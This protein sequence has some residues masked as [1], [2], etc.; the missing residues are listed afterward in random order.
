MQ[1]EIT[2]TYL[3]EK[4]RF[5]G[6]E[7][8][9]IIA[10]A[11]LTDSHKIITIKGPSA[12][13]E[14]KSGCDYVFFGKWSS[15]KNK[16]TGQMEQQF[17]FSSFV[18]EEPASREA[19]IAY[20]VQHGEGHGIGNSRAAALFDLF[21]ND[22]VKV[23]RED[24]LRVA[25]A[26]SGRLKISL[27]QAKQL[28]AG[29]LAN[30]AIEKTKLG[31]AS[32]LQGRG[33]ARSITHLSI[34]KWGVAAARVIRRD[35]FKLMAFKSCGFKRC[36]AMYLDLKLN[37]ARLKRQALCAWHSIARNTDGSTWFTEAHPT[38]FIRS[39]VAG[40]GTDAEKAL[41]LAIR[42][43]L[44]DEVCT[45]EGSLCE[46]QIADRRWLAEYSKSQHEQQIADALATSAGEECLWPDPSEIKSIDDH[47]RGE[48]IK[49]VQSTIGILGGSPGTGKTYTVASLVEL[50]G[51]RFGLE[52]VAI[53]APTG[54]AAVRVT[55]NLRY[56]GIN[57]TARTWQSMLARLESTGSRFQQKFLIGDESSMLDTDLMAAIIRARSK[58][59]HILLVGDVN[60]LPPVGHGS[61]L[62]DMIDSGI[63]YGELKE[64]KRNSGG[65]V[66]TC[67]MIRDNPSK[68]N[69]KSAG[70]NFVFHQCFKPEKQIESILSRLKQAKADGLD[71]VW[72]CQ[73]VVAVNE[74]SPLSRKELNSIIQQELNPN[75]KSAGSESPFRTGDKIVNLKNGWFDLS[76]FPCSVPSGE[77]ETNEDNQVYVANGELAKVIE[78]R[79]NQVIAELS[80]P[81]RL[82]KFW[83]GKKTK[84]SDK[85]TSAGE[86]GEESSSGCTFDLGYALSVHKSQ[87]SDWPRVLVVIDEYAGAKMICDRSWIYTAISRAKNK[88][89]LFG[90]EQVA[91]TM[92]KFSNIGNRKTFLRERILQARSAVALACV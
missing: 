63:S 13:D 48:L 18:M 20:L 62:R 80:L 45:R 3:S 67:A 84:T 8:D 64:I 33:F 74:R 59:T 2:V 26:T 32:L 70:S 30:A 58:G 31:L 72:D 42:G 68:V 15:Y 54:K 71:P 11:E 6:D 14:L 82:I 60:Q 40:V 52:H 16:R 1:S 37:P 75:P 69:W 88:C 36:D 90:K 76:E 7:I 35:P 28:S 81:Y 91:T 12:A 47:Q 29:L 78:V 22:A 9:T 73:V 85:D 83:I 23:C 51:F 5:C 53:G 92:C 65:I 10:S 21:G 39:S 49:A 77:A 86:G 66:E 44:M 27:G 57:L 55:E 38:S 17:H 4:I 89:E 19:I 25:E 79:G 56:R 87:G 50:I 61:P 24:P 46:M 43:K 34:Q 41:K